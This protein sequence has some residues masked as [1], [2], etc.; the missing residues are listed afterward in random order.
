MQKSLTKLSYNNAIHYVTKSTAFL[1][2]TSRR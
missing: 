1:Y 2:K